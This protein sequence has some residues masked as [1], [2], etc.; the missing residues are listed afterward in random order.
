MMSMVGM[1]H[2]D[3]VRTQDAQKLWTGKQVD[4]D[5]GPVAEY[6]KRHRSPHRG[7]LT[8]TKL[9]IIPLREKYSKQTICIMRSQTFVSKLFSVKR[10]EN[11][12]HRKYTFFLGP[13]ENASSTISQIEQNL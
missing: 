13:A 11:D 4:K 3:T 2:M 5:G 8:K 6:S 7:S 10:K 9:F 12:L 1:I